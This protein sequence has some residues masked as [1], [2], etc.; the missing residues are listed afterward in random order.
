[1][2]FINV[3][4]IYQNS[5]FCKYISSITIGSSYSELTLAVQYNSETD[6]RYS[7]WIQAIKSLKEK[8]RTTITKEEKNWWKD[9]GHKPKVI[10][11]KLE[12]NTKE[13]QAEILESYKIP[14]K[15]L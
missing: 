14:T 8:P 2:I 13:K 1:M 12:G 7:P 4:I 9:N 6:E 10:Q 15:E 5:V 3:Y 11:K